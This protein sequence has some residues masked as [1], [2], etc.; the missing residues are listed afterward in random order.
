MFLKYVITF[1]ISHPT[2][3]FTLLT[4]IAF[5]FYVKSTIQ[6]EFFL[7]SIF[8]GR[9]FYDKELEIIRELIRL[10]IYYMPLIPL[11]SP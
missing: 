10:F 8:F 11:G 9:D 4:E 3:S 5:V 6:L 2:I 1:C 7:I